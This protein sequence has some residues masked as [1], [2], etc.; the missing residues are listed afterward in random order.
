MIRYHGSRHIRIHGRVAALSGKPFTV[1]SLSF[2][3]LRADPHPDRGPL[4]TRLPSDR[5]ST[6]VG[7][8]LGVNDTTCNVELGFKEDCDALDLG[9]EESWH[10]MEV[11]SVSSEVSSTNAGVCLLIYTGSVL[12]CAALISKLALRGGVELKTASRPTAH[13]DAC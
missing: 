9:R 3:A 8:S 11:N 2:A 12:D 1:H 6:R 13:R 4:G 10:K 7:F 5:R